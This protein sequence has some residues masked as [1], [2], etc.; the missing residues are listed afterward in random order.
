MPDPQET[1]LPIVKR[2]RNGKFKALIDIEDYDPELVATYAKKVRVDRDKG[3]VKIK[4]RIKKGQSILK[5]KEEGEDQIPT[6][7][8]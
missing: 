1:Q 7:R 2:K 8:L 5:A 3:V 6:T 4:G